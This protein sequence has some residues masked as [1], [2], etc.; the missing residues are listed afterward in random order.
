MR[1]GNNFILLSKEGKPMVWLA[2]KKKKTPTELPAWVMVSLIPVPEIKDGEP[3][4]KMII[5]RR[6]YGEETIEAFIAE[7]GFTKHPSYFTCKV[8]KVEKEVRVEMV[9]SVLPTW[10]RH[11]T[12]PFTWDWNDKFLALWTEQQAANNCEKHIANLA[13]LRV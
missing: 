6:V 10:N 4:G 1:I 3:T 11:I 8:T 2:T 7:H 9:H 12:I 5:R 13:D